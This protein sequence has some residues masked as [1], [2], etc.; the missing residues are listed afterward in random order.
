MLLPRFLCCTLMC[1]LS[2]NSYAGEVQQQLDELIRMAQGKRLGIITNP[3]AGD[4]NGSPDADYLAQAKG[5]T[6]TAFFAPEHGLR[7]ILPA[8]RGDKDYVDPATSIPVYAVYGPRKAPT[9]EQLDK[10]DILV[11]DLQ[12]VGARFYTFMWTMTYC[13]DAAA[14]AGKQFVVIDRPNPVG[15]EKIEGPANQ[16]DYGL[17]GRL[18]PSQGLG[19]ATRHGM[20]VGEVATMW[21]AETTGPKSLLTVVKMKGWKRGQLWNETGRKFVPPSPNLRTAQATNVYPGTCIFEGTKLSE[22]RGTPR[23]FEMIGAPFV[24]AAQ[25]AEALTSQSLAGVTFEPVHYT[26]TSSK[27]SGKECGGVAMQV[28]DPEKFESVRTGLTMLK[29]ALKLYPDDMK[30]T[31]TASRLAGI[32]MIESRLNAESVDQILKSV[33]PSRERFLAIRKKYLLYN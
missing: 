13:M 3:A 8:G 23:P 4:E 21:N 33:G 2:F 14:S 10:L 12:D 28:T 22:G 1:A 26:P 9:A 15:G 11:Y 5:T 17:I 29:T 20:T 16:I 25:F 6:I 24:D 27:Y 32:P 31:G 18:L 7:G 19:V 30:S